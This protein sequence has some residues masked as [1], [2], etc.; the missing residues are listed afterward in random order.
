ME[1][2]ESLMNMRAEVVVSKHKA[3]MFSAR[4]AGTIGRLYFQRG[5]E[6]EVPDKFRGGRGRIRSMF[7]RYFA[8]IVFAKAV[9]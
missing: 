8:F 4:P 7:S 3:F 9:Y 1:K 5:V 6:N 2:T